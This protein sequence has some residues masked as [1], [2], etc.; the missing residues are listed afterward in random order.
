MLGRRVSPR[1]HRRGGRR[2]QAGADD[3]RMRWGGGAN[4]FN[5]KKKTKVKLIMSG[6]PTVHLNTAVCQHGKQL[7]E[8]SVIFTAAT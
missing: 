4:T 5:I 8:N 3:L 1:V 2:A 6:F 7:T